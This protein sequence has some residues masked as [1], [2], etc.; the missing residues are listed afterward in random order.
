MDGWRV[1]DRV[2]DRD[3]GRGRERR[4]QIGGDAWIGSRSITTLQC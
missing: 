3:V 2:G 4:C 1:T